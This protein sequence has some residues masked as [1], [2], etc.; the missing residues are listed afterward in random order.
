MSVTI[1]LPDSSV[2]VPDS[3]RGNLTAFREWAG[4][5]DLPEKTR[6]DFYRGEVWIDMGREQVFTHGQLKTR[7]STTLDTLTHASD[8]GYYFCNGILVTNI[9]ADLSGN[10][11]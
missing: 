2:F 7:I 10:P 6:T 8:M 4:D 1:Q 9:A 5:N 11:D 3:V